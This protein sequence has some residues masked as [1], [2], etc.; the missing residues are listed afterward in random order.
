MCALWSDCGE[1]L[2]SAG[3]THINEKL[4]FVLL[5]VAADLGRQQDARPCAEFTVLLV[6]FA[7]KNKFFKVDER[8]G[9]GRFLVAALVLGQLF[10]L[11]F[12]AVWW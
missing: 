4:D 9:D 10:Y 8:H 7:L 2:G 1:A 5:Q 3:G 12:Q 11:S 6:E